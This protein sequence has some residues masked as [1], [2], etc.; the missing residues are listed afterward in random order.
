MENMDYY[1]DKIADLL[2]ENHFIEK[3]EN[4]KISKLHY[5]EYC[6]ENLLKDIDNKLKDTMY[7]FTYDSKFVFK[8]LLSFDAIRDLLSDYDYSIKTFPVN[9]DREAYFAIGYAKPKLSKFDENKSIIKYF[10]EKFRKNDKI[11]GFIKDKI[12]KFNIKEI[13]VTNWIMLIAG[14]IIGLVITTLFYLSDNQI[15]IAYQEGIEVGQQQYQDYIYNKYDSL[16]CHL[17]K[18]QGVLFW[19]VIYKYHYYLEILNSNIF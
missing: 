8:I 4:F 17:Q 11:K 12:S 13:S 2:L 6:I 9:D 14:I 3:R 18:D 7:E 15:K 19:K 5:F 16:I 10:Y 1:Y